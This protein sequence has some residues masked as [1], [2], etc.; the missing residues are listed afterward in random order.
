MY[1]YKPKIKKI[2]ILG[3]QNRDFL[4]SLGVSEEKTGKIQF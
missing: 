4:A 1:A 2:S 3:K